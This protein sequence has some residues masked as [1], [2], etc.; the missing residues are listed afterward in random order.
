[1]TKEEFIIQCSQ[2]IFSSMMAN[3]EKDPDAKTAI[4]FAEQLWEELVKNDYVLPQ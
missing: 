3:P 2:K 1:M 4:L